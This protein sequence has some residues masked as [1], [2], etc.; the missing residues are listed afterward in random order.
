MELSY[1]VNDREARTHSQKV[2][3]LQPSGLPLREVSRTFGRVLTWD[4]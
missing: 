2:L 3:S 1:G 4:F